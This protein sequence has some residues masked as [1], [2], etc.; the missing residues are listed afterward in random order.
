VQL[1][2]A[3][4]SE[5]IAEGTPLEIATLAESMAAEDVLFDDAG[6]VDKDGRSL[7]DSA[8]VRRQ[9]ED[10]LAGHQ[11]TF[12]ALPAKASDEDREA[13]RTV[14]KERK[15]RIAA[16]KAKVAGARQAMQ[17]ARARVERRRGR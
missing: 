10:D 2:D 11:A 13:L 7:F 14:I 5:L 17:D 1:R 16:G 3:Q 8:A 12:D 15:D 4:T 6:P 9:A